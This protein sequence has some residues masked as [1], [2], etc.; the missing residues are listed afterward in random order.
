MVRLTCSILSTVLQAFESS[1]GGDET[2]IGCLYSPSARELLERDI[3]IRHN[4][5]Q[6]LHTLQE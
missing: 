2:V 6:C 4:R 1:I 5:F 3:Y